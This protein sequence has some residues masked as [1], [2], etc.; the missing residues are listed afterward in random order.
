MKAK[1]LAA[2][3]MSGASFL[4][5]MTGLVKAFRNEA[6]VKAVDERLYQQA[7][8]GIGDTADEV[9]ELKLRLAKLEKRGR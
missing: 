8:T 6:E 4:A 5:A 1:E 3:L 7:A 2:L 9:Y